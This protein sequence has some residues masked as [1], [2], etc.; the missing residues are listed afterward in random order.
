VPKDRVDYMRNAIER[1]VKNPELLAE[2]GKMKLDMVYRE[3]R[4][5]EEIVAKLYATP[6]ELIEKAKS[7]SP[8]LR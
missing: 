4:H 8:N 7:I 3:P 6:P 2:A 1:T 5:L